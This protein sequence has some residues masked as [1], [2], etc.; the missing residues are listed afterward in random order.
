[1]VSFERCREEVLDRAGAPAHAAYEAWKRRDGYEKV[2]AFVHGF[3]HRHLFRVTV[4]DLDHVKR[5]SEH[6][7]GDVQTEE[8]LAVIEDLTTPFA[9]QH[10]FHHWVEAHGRVPLWQEWS[11]WMWGDA[12]RGFVQPA[13]EAAGW[14]EADAD[15]RERIRRAI[16]WRLGKFYYSAFREVEA[17]T[18]LREEHGLALRYHLLADVLL[19]IDFWLGDAAVCVYFPNPKYRSGRAG[20]KPPASRFVGGAASPFTVLHLGI[21]RQGHGRFWTADPRSLE[22][23][24][25]T[26]HEAA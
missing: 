12:C 23:T 16:R 15:G 8:Q 20:R 11:A 19:R 7:L 26:I 24:A 4:G 13:T 22:A 2:V 14:H 1:M 6:A 9:L 5:E 3:A 10:I 17:L 18:R 25:R 21:E